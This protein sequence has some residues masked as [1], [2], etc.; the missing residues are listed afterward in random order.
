[1]KLLKTSTLITLCFFTIGIKAQINSNALSWQMNT[2]YNN[3][4][5]RD[6]HQQYDYRGY[7][8][9]LFSP[10]PKEI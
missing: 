2:A 5:L 4:L 8:T 7:L 3:Y 6:V 9:I 10:V 1:M